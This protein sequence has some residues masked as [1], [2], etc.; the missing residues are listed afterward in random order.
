MVIV[1]LSVMLAV[2]CLPFTYLPILL[3]AG[4]RATMG[5]DVNGPLARVLGWGYFVVICIAAVGAP[6]LL[7]L[8]GMGRY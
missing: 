1:E 5:D 7:V 8:T 6:I 2:V 4:D 3:A